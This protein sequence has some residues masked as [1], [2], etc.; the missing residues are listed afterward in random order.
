MHP[1]STAL[2][3]PVGTAMSRDGMTRAA[4]P[5]SRSALEE[6]YGLPGA[7]ARIDA[8]DA[9]SDDEGYFTFD[10]ATCYGRRAGGAPARLATDAL[11]D[12]SGAAAWDGGRLRLPFDLTDVVT[13]LRQERYRQAP[14]NW[15]ERVCAAP[16]ARSLYYF[17]RPA[18]PVAVRKHL[19][20]IR[21]NDWD[22]IG[23]PRWPI[24]VSV[25]TVMRHV[26]RL[27]LEQGVERV[28]FIWFWPDGASGCAVMTHDVEGP[29]GE[30]FCERLMDLDDMFGVKSAFQFVPDVRRERPTAL[31]EKLR[32]RRFEINLHDLSHDGHLFLNEHEFLQRAKQIN[33]YAREYQC[34]G[35]RSGAMYREQ[36]WYGALDVAY[37][38]SVPNAAH[39]EPQRGGCC[40]VMP[41]FVG[42]ILELPLT[43]T[44][45]YSLFH[46]LGDYSTTLWKRQTELL[47]SHN[48]LMTFITHPDYLSER[49]A[50]G[51]YTD[52]LTHLQT[53]RAERNVW[54][55]L[56]GEVNDWWRSRNAMR[57]VP[58]GDSWRIQGEGSR[59]AR[60]AW[61]TLDDGR[62]VYTLDRSR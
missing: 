62:V 55:A 34:R 25:E 6:Y 36:R 45:D 38:M 54:V 59:R 14:H 17:L 12:V 48:G 27:L 16:A 44:Q 50:R 49:R 5:A 7:L 39:L 4:R 46:I 58:A 43:T 10:G 26:L 28:P 52:L 18:L 15:L 61:A 19:Q 60:L 9:L 31:L 57:L 56:P 42:N 40:T 35:F 37:D 32:A 29:A 30:A 8:A 51:V 20:K 33:R 2:A 22:A 21:L 23:F 1:A 41:Y 47:L 53:L 3:D 24:D 13:N 11:P